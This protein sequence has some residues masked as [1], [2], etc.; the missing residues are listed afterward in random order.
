MKSKKIYILMGHPNTDPTLT[1]ELADAYEAGAKTAGHEV[2]R[3]NLGELSFD[4]VLHKGYRAIQE[5]EPDLKK[6]Q[7]DVTWCETFVLFYPLW[8]S[9]VPALLKGLIDRAWLP[10]F[11]F[12]F[13]KT[14]SGKSTMGWRKLLKGRKA[15][16]VV[17]MKNFPIV[18]R[19]LY[20][21]YASDIVNAILR[22]SGFSV[23]LSEVGNSEGLSEGAKAA[24][25]KK[26][27]KLAKN[28]H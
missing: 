7:E 26:M 24:W 13:I 18:E 3:A 22:F 21:N 23:R 17:L 9:S 27:G 10:R 14:P 20:G 2:R 4:P 11:A 5:L 1:S 28:A 12:S 15:R 16:V 6:L 8:W 19:F 25:L